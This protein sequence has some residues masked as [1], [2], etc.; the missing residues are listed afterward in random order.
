MNHGIGRWLKLTRLL[1]TMSAL[2]EYS[3]DIN[4]VS[5]RQRVYHIFFIRTY[6]MKSAS[7]AHVFATAGLC[8]AFPSTADYSSN[9]TNAIASYRVQ[10]SHNCPAT[11]EVFPHFTVTNGSVCATQNSSTQPTM[12]GEERDYTLTY[13]AEGQSSWTFWIDNLAYSAG[14]VIRS[15]VEVTCVRDVGKCFIDI[16]NVE[17]ISN[18][19]QVAIEAT[20]CSTIGPQSKSSPTCAPLICRI[21]SDWQ[22]PTQNRFDQQDSSKS[23]PPTYLSADQSCVSN[24]TL[25]QSDEACCRNAYASDKICTNQ[26]PALE[27]VCEDAYSY[28]F[29]D[30]RASYVYQV[31]LDDA[32]TLQ[33]K[34]CP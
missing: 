16:S 8:L 27:S 23:Y 21:D 25:Y 13:G 22:C 18:G 7:I 12:Q 19:F 28:A 9:S 10:F 1:R 14:P 30:N 20:S 24:C 29:D 11:S 31:T 6:N 33:I 3:R 32:T 34:A 26:N 2:E 17:G 4:V 5:A 15:L